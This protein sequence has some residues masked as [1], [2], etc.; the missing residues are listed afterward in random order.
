MKTKQM[1]RK[2]EIHNCER[3]CKERHKGREERTE[4]NKEKRRKQKGREEKKNKVDADGRFI[5]KC[6][7]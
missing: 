5:L 4:Q 1:K 7:K 3:N 2:K 6:T